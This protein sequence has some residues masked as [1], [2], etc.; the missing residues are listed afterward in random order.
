MGFRWEVSQP[1]Q[2]TEMNRSVIPVCRQDAVTPAQENLNITS[3]QEV[4]SS[5]LQ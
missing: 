4:N 5:Q 2:L 3:G 1:P